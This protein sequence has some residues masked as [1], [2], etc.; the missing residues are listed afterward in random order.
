MQAQLPI[1]FLLEYLM[2]M[3]QKQ[4]ICDVLALGIPEVEFAG[5]K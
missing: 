1:G 3:I 5:L 4:G 2:S